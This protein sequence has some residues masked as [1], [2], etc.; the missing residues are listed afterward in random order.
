MMKRIITL[1][2]VLLAILAIFYF[3]Q[4]ANASTLP[5]LSLNR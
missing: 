4:R 2:G 3:V 1:A 5:P